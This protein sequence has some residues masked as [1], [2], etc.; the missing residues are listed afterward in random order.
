M[1]N[2]EPVG[3]SL[4]LL[5]TRNRVVW[6]EDGGR[7]E[8]LSGTMSARIAAEPRMSSGHSQIRVTRKA[9]GAVDPP[10]NRGEALRLKSRECTLLGFATWA[11]LEMADTSGHR[12]G[13]VKVAPFTL[14]HMHVHR[15]RA[16]LP[17]ACLELDRLASGGRLV[18]LANLAPVD[19]VVKGGNVLRAAVL[20]FEVIRVLPDVDT[21]D[22]DVV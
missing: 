12:I 9:A 5:C 20:V 11:S 8:F 2:T 16:P 14:T 4:L 21:E 6:R 10:T 19:D 1:L 7:E 15:L 17:F 3:I 22:R 18:V 13:V